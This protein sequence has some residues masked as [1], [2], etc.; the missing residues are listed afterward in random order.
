MICKSVLCSVAFITLSVSMASMLIVGGVVS[1]TVVAVTGV[2][3][4]PCGVVTTI[5]GVNCP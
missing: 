3:V 2:V 4:F 1:T 5:L